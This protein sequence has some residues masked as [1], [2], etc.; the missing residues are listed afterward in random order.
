MNRYWSKRLG[1]ITA[2]QAGEQPQD[3]TYIKLN[4]NENPYPPSGKVLA[5]LNQVDTEM[6]RRYPDPDARLLK[7]AIASYYDLEPG[8]V[9]TGNG[10]DEVLGHVFMAF[11]DQ[12]APVCFPDITYSFYPIYCARYGL[13][14]IQIPLT[15]DFRIDPDTYPDRCGGIILANPNAPTGRFL[16]PAQIKKLLGRNPDS[17]I[18]IDEAY[19][20]FGGASC[21]PMI[22]EYP[23]LLVVQTLSKSRSLAG[24]RVGF[25]LGQMGLICGL[26]IAKNSFNSY[27]LGSL[28]IA[29]A[30]EAI[31]DQDHYLQCTGKVAETR[32]WLSGCLLGLG[33]DVIPSLANFLMIRHAS[34]QAEVLYQKLRERGILVRYFNA[35][36]ISDY[37]RVSIGT[38]A[39]MQ[40]FLRNIGE[41]T[42]A[43]TSIGTKAV[44]LPL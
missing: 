37:I 21:I 41:I 17:V 32:D 24:L 3:R 10:S 30:I 18:V 12:S 38:R 9:F 13:S 27:P 14:Y 19:I 43:G 11:F 31:N 16:E 25:A 6:L 33:F 39:D 4:T 35:P 22:R 44:S 20:D 15:S 40:E 23:N 2:Y 7:Q 28:A 1:E 42:A 36:R 34:V 26:E 29:G 8:M 5:R